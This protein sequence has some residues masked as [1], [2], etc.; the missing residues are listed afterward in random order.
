MTDIAASDLYTTPEKRATIERV[1]AER[2]MTVV[3]FLRFVIAQHFAA[4]GR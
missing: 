1:A 2:G 3:E 4:T